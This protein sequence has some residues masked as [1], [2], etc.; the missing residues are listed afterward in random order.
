MSMSE[1]YTVVKCN[2]RND[3]LNEYL[4][5]MSIL[6]NNLTNTLI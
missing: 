6:S 2:V 4:K 1:N 5:Q 3:E